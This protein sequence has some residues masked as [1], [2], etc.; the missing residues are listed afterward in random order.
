[1]ST[2]VDIINAII[3]ELTAITGIKV[4]T[5]F[6]KSLTKAEINLPYIGVVAS[7]EE[8]LVED[9][10]DIHYDLPIDL[11]LITEE[12]YNDVEGLIDDIKTAFQGITASPSSLHANIF[13]LIV[14]TVSPV[15]LDDL[16]EQNLSSVRIPLRLRYYASKSGF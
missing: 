14:G 1:M 2:R 11:F 8:P 16:D 10:T 12:Q 4:A 15:R 6:T 9:A 3:V 7:D 13:Y 5:R